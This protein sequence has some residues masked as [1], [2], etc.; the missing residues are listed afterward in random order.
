MVGAHVVGEHAK[1]G[2]DTQF[3]GEDEAPRVEAGD[4]G[5]SS[6]LQPTIKPKTATA[7]V[8]WESA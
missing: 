1:Q 7:C 5:E 3:G 8:I 2:G 6:I 4:E